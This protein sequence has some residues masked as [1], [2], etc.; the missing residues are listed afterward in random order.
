MVRENDNYIEIDQPPI[1]NA[2]FISNAQLEENSSASTDPESEGDK[3]PVCDSV[4]SYAVL[5]LSDSE[6]DECRLCDFDE[7][8][9]VYWLD[10]RVND[11][12]DEIRRL[13]VK[14]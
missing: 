8:S 1:L 12:E 9:N 2:D 13:E 14:K 3:E 11:D 4:D 10:E 7:D 5:S 6:G